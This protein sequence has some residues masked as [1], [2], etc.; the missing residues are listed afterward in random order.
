MTAQEE[1]LDLSR[2]ADRDPSSMDFAYWAI[3]PWTGEVEATPDGSRRLLTGGAE[4]LIGDIRRFEDCGVSSLSIVVL[5]ANLDKT[6][7]NMDRFANQIISK[8]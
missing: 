3:W 4:D 1:V 7:E 8:I 5:G 6:L 2:R